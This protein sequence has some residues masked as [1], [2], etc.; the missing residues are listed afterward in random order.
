MRVFQLI[1]TLN[2]GDAIS[3]EALTIKRLLTEQGIVNEIYGLQAHELLKHELRPWSEL[4]ANLESSSAESGD[5]RTTVVLHYSIGSPLNDLYRSLKGVKRVLIYHNLTPASWFAN[6]NYRVCEDLKS[7][8]LELPEL[9]ACSDKLVAD[10]D[11]NSSELNQL[12][13]SNTSVLPLVLD[14]QKWDIEENAG[15]RQIL[16][17]TGGKNWLHVGR[18]APNKCIEDII[19]AFYFYCYKI[20]KKSR[21]WLVGHDIDTEIYSFELRRLVAYLQ[22]KENVSFV[23]AVA[24]CELKAFYRHSDVYLCMS[25]HEGFCVPLIEAM[26]F[27]LPVIAYNSSAIGQTLGDAGVLVE[28]KQPHLIAELTDLVVRDQSLRK[29]MVEKGA[30][31]AERFGLDSFREKLQLIWQ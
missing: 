22:L 20:D 30:A 5:E 1:H 25:E 24:D 15:I 21:L 10:S 11:F 17:N 2:Y 18:V 14:E 12:G 13:F 3:G 19:K 16:S 29:E 26:Y 8:L 7:G 28:S 31:Q 9:L 4:T 23:G 27:G 6:Y